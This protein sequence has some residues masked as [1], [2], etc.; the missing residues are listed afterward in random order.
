MQNKF[1]KLLGIGC[2]IEASIL[3]NSMNG[4]CQVKKK[5][6][7]EYIPKRGRASRIT[8]EVTGQ[9][10]IDVQTER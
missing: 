9:L 6:R 10:K 5:K 3:C 7:R 8:K 2:I 4:K 1:K